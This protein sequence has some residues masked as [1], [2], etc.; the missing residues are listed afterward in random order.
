M[1]LSQISDR[2]LADNGYTRED[3]R[4]LARNGCLYW[5][6]GGLFTEADRIRLHMDGLLEPVVPPRASD[7]ELRERRMKAL[8]KFDARQVKRGRLRVRFNVGDFRANPVPLPVE[9]VGPVVGEAEY[10]GGGLYRIVRRG[11]Q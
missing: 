4:H 5:W 2:Q 7:E 3:A 10:V 9:A 8:A 11:G 1:K 6:S